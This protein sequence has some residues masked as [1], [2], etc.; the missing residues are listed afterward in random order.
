[1]PIAAYA[2]CTVPNVKASNAP[3]AMLDK[4]SCFN[5]ITSIRCY[6]VLNVLTL[7]NDNILF[8]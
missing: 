5:F 7:P 3:T 1:M 6:I 2:G 4:I 8:C